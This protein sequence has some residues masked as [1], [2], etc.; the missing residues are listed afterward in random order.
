[1]TAENLETAKQIAT[2]GLS[3]DIVSKSST[4]PPREILNAFFACGYDDGVDES[5]IHWQPCSLN[6]MDF[7]QFFLWW[8]QIH[9]D[10]NIDDLGVT[11]PDFSR[12]F[13]TAID[14]T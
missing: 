12:W 14:I 9:P 1:M 7:N 8:K 10:A 2:D 3:F 4:F 6:T 11:T 13:A 5:T